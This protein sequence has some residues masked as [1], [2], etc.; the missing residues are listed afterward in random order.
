[1]IEESTLTKILTEREKEPLIAPEPSIRIRSVF[2]SY[3]YLVLNENIPYIIRDTALIMATLINK[4]IDQSNIGYIL[5][6][7]ISRL[8]NRNVRLR[9][10]TFN[11]NGRK[12]VR[13][14]NGIK[15]VDEVNLSDIDMNRYLEYLRLALD[16]LL[17]YLDCPFYDTIRKA[18]LVRFF[19]DIDDVLKE[20]LIKE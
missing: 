1:M 5:A 14:K 18:E 17:N 4:D 8:K 9:D 3:R 13:T 7:V 6:G 12:V 2:D 19:Y 11:V 10:L 15:D 20:G 16:P